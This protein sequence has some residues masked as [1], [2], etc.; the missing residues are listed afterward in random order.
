MDGEALC[1]DNG[2]EAKIECNW[3]VWGTASKVVQERDFF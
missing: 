1:N 3:A 2:R